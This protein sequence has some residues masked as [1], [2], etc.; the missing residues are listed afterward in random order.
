[1]NNEEWLEKVILLSKDLFNNNPTWKA[2]L[3]RVDNGLLLEADSKYT[4]EA[5]NALIKKIKDET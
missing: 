3:K 2:Q 5:W 1:M 4:Q